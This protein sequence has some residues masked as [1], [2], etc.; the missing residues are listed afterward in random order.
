MSSEAFFAG[1]WKE[2][3]ELGA[4]MKNTWQILEHHDCDGASNR[5]IEII[6]GQLKI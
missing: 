6:D 5:I 4:S 3:I 2:Y 1:S